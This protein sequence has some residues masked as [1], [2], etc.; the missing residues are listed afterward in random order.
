MPICGAPWQGHWITSPA[1]TAIDLAG[2]LTF[3]KAVIALDQAPWAKRSGGALT[4]V[5]ALRSV[6]VRA[7]MRAAARVLSG[8]DFATPL[9]DSVRETQSRVLIDRMG[10]PAPVLQQRFD[11]PSGRVARPDFFFEDH[12]HAGEFDGVGKYLD[13]L[14]LRGRTPEE[15]LIEEKDRADELV[16]VVRGL[17]RWRTPAL[18]D[19]RQLYD[20]LAGAGLP[21]RRPRPRLGQHWA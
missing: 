12:G 17:S 10:F 16:R 15:A 14:I 5:A 19:P 9:S 3:M 13:P 8:I 18:R 11:L 2:I 21:T 4:D 1:Q 7:P 20:I 6:A